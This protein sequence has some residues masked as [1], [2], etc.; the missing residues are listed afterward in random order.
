MEEVEFGD[1]FDGAHG[2]RKRKKSGCLPGGRWGHL[3]EQGPWRRSREAIE[4]EFGVGY[5]G[6]ESPVKQPR[7]DVKKANLQLRGF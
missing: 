2:I 1:G 4:P 6:H 5:T 3:L 7:G